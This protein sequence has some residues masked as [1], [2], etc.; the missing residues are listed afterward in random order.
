[1]GAVG[2]GV[3]S[4]AKLSPEEISSLFLYLLIAQGFFAGFVIGKLSEGTLRAGVKHSFILTIAAW[5]I[6]TGVRALL[7]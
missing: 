3:S 4:A 7:T 2:A 1:L 5:L 6:S